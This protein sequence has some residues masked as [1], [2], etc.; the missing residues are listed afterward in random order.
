MDENSGITVSNNHTIDWWTLGKYFANQSSDDQAMFLHG[1]ATGFS[2]MKGLGSGYQYLA[3]SDDVTKLGTQ[4]AQDIAR[5]LSD[6]RDY[7]E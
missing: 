4:P 1:A 7:T 3:I 5:M 6:L 2:D